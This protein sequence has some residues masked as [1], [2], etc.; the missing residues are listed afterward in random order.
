MSSSGRPGAQQI[1]PVTAIVADRI[2]FRTAY[3]VP[4]QVAS[5]LP[6]QDP[7]EIAAKRLPD[8]S[9]RIGPTVAAGFPP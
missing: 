5:R 9:I 8:V 4:P 6:V 2:A 1:L 3:R 7:L